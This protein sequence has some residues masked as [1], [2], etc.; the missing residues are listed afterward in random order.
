MAEFDGI[1]TEEQVRVLGLIT[2]TP[3]PGWMSDSDHRVL[4]DIAKH[5]LAL[6]AGNLFGWKVTDAG[7]CLLRLQP[8]LK[9]MRAWVEADAAL[10]KSRRKWERGDVDGIEGIEKPYQR[11]EDAARTIWRAVRAYFAVEGVQKDG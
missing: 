5:S 2:Q 6:Y 11:R 3:H 9:A 4:V 10:V 8:M 1:L 7:Q